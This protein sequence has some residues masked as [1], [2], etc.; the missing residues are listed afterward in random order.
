M[1]KR[2]SVILSVLIAVSSFVIFPVFAAEKGYEK[3][4]TVKLEFRIDE[5]TQPFTGFEGSLT[6]SDKLTINKESVT[7]PHI[8][9]INYSVGE[10]NVPFNATS[11]SNFDISSDK[12]FMKAEFTFNEES[13]TLPVKCVLDDIYLIENKK[14]FVVPDNIEL[15]YTLSVYE[16]KGEQETSEP[17]PTSEVTQPTTAATEPATAHIEPTEP[18]VK[19][20]KKNN[21]IKLKAK[22]KT[23]K[24]KKLIKKSKI[25]KP[26][27]VKNAKG[28]VTYKKLKKGSTAKLFKNVTVGRTSG[29]I[30]I[31]KGV[32]KKKTYKLS[33]SVTAKGNSLYKPKTQTLKLKI[34]IK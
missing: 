15:P 25:I 16:V 6:F 26:V 3:G 12:V 18:N 19:P 9:G 8:A 21:P 31:K 2:I 27:T 30:K 10:G 32:Y 24:A 23:V 34:R 11:L 22:T 17:T 20:E 7:F 28:K 4:Q 14:D 5:I 1:K 29:K 33:L 13:E